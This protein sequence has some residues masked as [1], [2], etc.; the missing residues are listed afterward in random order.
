MRIAFDV[1]PLSHPRTGVGNYVRG[2]LARPRRGGRRRST[3]CVAFAP[4]SRPGSQADPRGARGRLDV[5]RAHAR[6]AVVARLPRWRWSRL[7]RPP[8]ER[9]LGPVD[10]APLQRLDG[11]RRSG[12][13]SGATMVHD[14]VPLCYPEW[15]TP[16]TQSMHGYK[17]RTRTADCDL[18]FVN[19]AYTG[20]DVGG[21]L[22]VPARADPRR[23]AGRR[24]PRSRRTATRA[25]LGRAV[26]A[27]ASPRSSR[28]R[29]CET[30]VEA[31]RPLRRRAGARGRRRQPAG[32]ISR[33]LDDRGS[34][35]SASSPTERAAAADAAAPPCSSTRRASRAS[36]CRSSR[37]W[38]A[39]CPSSCPS[40]PSMDEA[41]GDAAVRASIPTIPMRSRPSIRA[42]LAQRDELARCRDRARARSSPGA[43]A[44]G[45]PSA[46]RTRR[47]SV[48]G[49]LDV[50]P[51]AADA[52][53][54]RARDVRGLA[55]R[56]RGVPTWSSRRS[57]SAG[58]AGRR[59]SPA[60]CSGIRAAR[61]AR[62]RRRRRCPATARSSAAAARA[63]CPVDPHRARPRRAPA[64]GG[65]PA[66]ARGS[67][68]AQ[69]FVRRLRGSRPR[70]RGLRVHEARGRRAARRRPLSGST[71]CP[72][73]LEPVFTPGR[74]R[75]RG[76][77]RAR[78]RDARAAQEPRPRRSRPRLARVSSCASSA[79]LAGD[80]RRGKHVA[81]LG[82][83]S[84]DEELAALYR[85]ARSL[86]FPSLYEG[87][88]HSRA[89]GD[90]VR[91]AGRD[92][93]AAA[94]RRRSSAGLPVLVD[95]LD[96]DAIAAGIETATGAARRARPARARARAAYY[97]GRAVD[98]V[99]S[100]PPAGARMTEPLVVVDAD[101]L[102]R[103]RTG[104]ETYVRNLLRELPGSLRRRPG[105]RIA[106][107]HAAS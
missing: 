42:A 95:P 25:E 71:S 88:G 15:V 82:R 93:R 78:R 92:E 60:T 74:R 72:N 84:D 16:R 35:S 86:V 28:A 87:F 14:L 104:D 1:S 89:R 55:A 99:A 68:G 44:A 37:R 19:S 62:P 85:G 10:V 61:R 50:A 81:W 21:A 30:L 17:Y 27:H 69:R 6:P 96:V 29:I 47:R 3:S 13:R 26:R 48:N 63:R 2:S 52:R 101:V 98:A 94:R 11:T 24:R 97:V 39:A 22:G 7:G 59:P 53:R 18:V 77:L 100:T 65:L 4:T 91:H 75:C 79:R 76:E 90:G 34:V 102:G 38:R 40:H 56:S 51:L 33:L 106:A 46:R 70:R 49:R 23:A 66:L 58:R 57:A 73:A 67:T 64:P 83:R 36:A 5:E 103:R 12:R 31:W 41:C 105:L 43:P 9:F 45:D 8:L 80:W 32:A 54:H 20:R 107:G